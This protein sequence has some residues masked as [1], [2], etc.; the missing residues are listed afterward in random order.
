MR[1]HI[2]LKIIRTDGL[3][4]NAANQYII[5]RRPYQNNIIYRLLRNS[6]IPEYDHDLVLNEKFSIVKGEILFDR[7]L[8]LSQKFTI[9]I[10][11]EDVT[12]IDSYS[13]II[14][15]KKIKSISHQYNSANK[16]IFEIQGVICEKH[17]YIISAHA[18]L[19]GDNNISKGDFINMQSYPVL[20][21]GYPNF[22][23]ITLKEIK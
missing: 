3:R 13:K 17:R 19:D 14:T 9:Y 22:V 1:D 8:E 20:T 5:Y 7:P 23:S 2:Y 11:L 6:N 4:C 18:D 15:E 16:L 12:M 21:H 10:R